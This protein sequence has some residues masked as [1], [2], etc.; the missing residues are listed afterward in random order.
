MN[1]LFNNQLY[2]NV[3]RQRRPRTYRLRQ[4]PL[5]ENFTDAEI[6]SRFRFTRET[7]SFIEDLVYNDLVRPTRRNHA[8]SVT[9]QVLTALRFFACGSFQQVVGDIIGIDKST[10]SRVVIAFCHALL[11]RSK[12]FINFPFSDE[13]KEK[14]KQ[15]F[16]KI[17]GFPSVVGCIDGTHVRLL[18]APHE[19]ENDY[20]NRKSFHSINVQCI[21]DHTG[22]FLDVV[23]KWPGC[24]HDS[25]IFRNSDVK[26]YLERNHKTLDKG[27][28]L[29]DSGYQLTNYLITP[30]T[31]PI[32]PAQKRFNKAQKVTRC[33]VE[34]SFG[35]FKRRFSCVQVG[36][37]VQPEKACLIIGACAILHNIAVLRNEEPFE[38]DLLNEEFECEPVGPHPSGNLMRN[39]IAET[40]FS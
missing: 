28:L 29:G 1:S 25:F 7:I 31:N 2:G 40:F 20:V 33:S 12:D 27:I 39:H 37:R 4:S 18:L 22:K 38:D 5:I 34:R 15:G 9:T 14:I 24:T 19:G 30:Y 36:L 3:A 35:Q 11:K 23:A 17:G 21:T 26:E 13:E 16:F 6:R 32:T 8:L 10:V